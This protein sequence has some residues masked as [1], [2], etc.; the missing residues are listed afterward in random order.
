MSDPLVYIIA[1]EPSGD[2]LAARLIKAL[3][4]LTDGKVRFAGIGGE[5]MRAEGLPSLFPQADLAVMGFAEVVPRIPKILRRLKET[6]A[7]IEAKK[8]S[9]IVTVDSWGFTGR[10]AKALKNQGSTIPRLHYVAPMVWAW[11]E[12]RARALAERVDR[13]LCLLPNEP[14]YFERHGLQAVH[15]GHSV[16]E[17]LDEPGDGQGFRKRHGIPADAP[18][19]CVLPGSRTSETS[20]LLPVFA[21][22]AGL[23]ATRFPG[24]QVVVPSVETVAEPVRRAVAGWSVPALVVDSAEKWDA[25]AASDAALAASGT[26]AL[27]LAVSKVPMVIGY[28]VAP[29]TAAIAR[30]LLTI[31]YVCLLNLLVDRLVVPEL[32]QE[33]CVPADLADALSPLMRDGPERRVQLEGCAEAL[34]ALGVDGESPSL[35]A[36]REALSMMVVESATN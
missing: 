1:G 26:V 35:R 25:F 5:A 20:R 22:T 31:K 24:L 9:L 17:R 7:D 14:A 28:R 18:L 34:R 36:A 32:L 10:V 21:E 19:L 33:K 16:L 6:L 11:K 23:M 3:K 8:P 2:I 12:K 30:R 13:L 4:R 15:V 29:M 27:E